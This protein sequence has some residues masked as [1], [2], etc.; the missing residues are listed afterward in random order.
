MSLSYNDIELQITCCEK[1]KKKKKKKKRK[2]VHLDDNLEWN[3]HFQHVCIPVDVFSDK[4]I[5]VTTT[6][7]SVL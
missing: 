1:K 6:Q 5:S 3:N 4:V 2:G 7:S